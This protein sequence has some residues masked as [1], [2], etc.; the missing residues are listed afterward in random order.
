LLHLRL[1]VPV[2]KYHANPATDVAHA[3]MRAV[4]TLLDTCSRTRN[5]ASPECR[6]GTHECVRHVGMAR[7]FTTGILENNCFNLPRPLPHGRAPML[8]ARSSDHRIG[9]FG[10]LQRPLH[11]SLT[12]TP[13]ARD[14]K[15]GALPRA[16]SQPAAIIATAYSKPPFPQVKRQPPCLQVLS[17]RSIC[18]SV[19]P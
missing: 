17:S 19:N 16:P 18:S 1:V 10:E 9:Q 4:S 15:P 13:A 14:G 12:D 8:R 3:L 7:L 11:P 6:R 2:T 5:R